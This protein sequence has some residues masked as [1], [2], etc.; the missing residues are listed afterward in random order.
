MTWGTRGVNVLRE[1][2]T[3][4]CGPEKKHG[5]TSWGGREATTDHRDILCWAKEPVEGPVAMCDCANSLLP[6]CALAWLEKEAALGKTGSKAV[7]GKG[8]VAG[9]KEGAWHSPCS[10]CGLTL[11]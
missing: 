2:W 3:L 10:V 7:R 8:G 11:M 1:L 4:H 9:P 5:H 6:L